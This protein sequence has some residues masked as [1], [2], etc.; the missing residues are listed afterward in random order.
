MITKLRYWWQ[1]LWSSY[2]FAPTLIVLSAV[3]LALL[4]VLLEPLRDLHL[5][6]RW[7]LFFGA[8]PSV[9]SGLLTTVASSMITVAGVVFSIT[10]VALSLTASQYTSRLIRNF[11]R[12][13]VNQVV[14]GVFVGIFAYCL[15]VLRTIREGEKGHSSRRRRCLAAW[16]SHWWGLACCSTL[17]II[18]RHPSRR[19][20]LL[21]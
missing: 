2:W 3:A 19:R 10:L 17:S 7:P 9:A 13:R 4:L 18:L 14:L 8:S 16:S 6:E 20:A 15:V 11:M 1:E 21:R 12:D 5:G